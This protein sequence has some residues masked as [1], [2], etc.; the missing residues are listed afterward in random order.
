[1]YRYVRIGTVVR[2]KL[3]PT[4]LHN[5][6]NLLKGSIQIKP[7]NRALRGSHCQRQSGLIAQTR[8]DVFINQGGL[9]CGYRVCVAPI[10]GRSR[11]HRVL[12]ERYD[13][14]YHV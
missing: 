7:S 13:S 11:Y 9:L 8:R 4:Y 14:L 3:C 5:P 6:F 2:Q 10:Y 12:R 1:M